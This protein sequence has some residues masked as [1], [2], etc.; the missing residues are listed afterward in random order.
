MPCILWSTLPRRVSSNSLCSLWWSADFLAS[1]SEGS[2]RPCCKF[3]VSTT[4]SNLGDWYT[5]QFQSSPVFMCTTFSIQIA[6][7]VI[8]KS[9][10][11]GSCLI[12]LHSFSERASTCTIYCISVNS[13]S[14]FVHRDSG[15]IQ[16]ILGLLQILI[17]VHWVHC[18]EKHWLPIQFETSS[19]Q[20]QSTLDDGVP[21][22][23]VSD[24]VDAVGEVVREQYIVLQ[25]RINESTSMS[26]VCSEI[27]EM[28]GIIRVQSS[29]ETFSPVL[30]L[31]AK[32]GIPASIGH[33]EVPAN[34]DFNNSAKSSNLTRPSSSRWTVSSCRNNLIKIFDTSKQPR[35][36]FPGSTSIH[37][38]SR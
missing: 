9:D 1:G 31:F 11:V 17:G 33:Y 23:S 20:N 14:I 29:I 5:L 24:V 10:C 21:V 16:I 30:L 18:S 19:S 4:R 22:V 27:Q 36:N 25:C 2:R 28:F 8:E 12:T 32:R 6:G 3:G 15:F 7:C 13:L 38:P 37:F 26:L 35:L 34:L